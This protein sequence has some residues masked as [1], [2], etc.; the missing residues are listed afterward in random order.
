[1]FNRVVTTVA[2]WVVMTPA[3]AAADVTI[4]TRR[5]EAGGRRAIEY[6]F[7]AKGIDSKKLVLRLH[8]N[9][10]GIVSVAPVTP[11]DRCSGPTLDDD[12]YMWTCTLSTT[13]VS[14]SFSVGGAASELAFGTATMEITEGDSDPRQQ[15]VDGLETAYNRSLV[16]TVVGGGISVLGDDYTDFKMDGGALRIVNDSQLRSSGLFG[17]LFHLTDVPWRNG[18]RKQFSALLGLEFTQGTNNFLDGFQ[19]GL[20]WEL[21]KYLTVVGGFALRK[22]EEL[23]HGFEQAASRIIV[24]Q[25]ANNDESYARFPTL[26]PDAIGYD[27][28]KLELLDGLPLNDPATDN[29]YFSGSPILESYNRSYFIGLVV[30]LNLGA[31]LAPQAAKE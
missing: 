20:G 19:F 11:A 25:Q 8:R 26:A 21:S 24:A 27:P 3:L 28:K 12:T 6:T 10:A 4:K 14:G 17:A 7:D 5:S 29:P 31:L 2:L 13:D 16:Q 18:E 9:G 23:S 1:M 30:P 22:G 15:E